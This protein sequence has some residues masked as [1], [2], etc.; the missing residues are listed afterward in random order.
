MKQNKLNR[1]FIIIFFI[2]T[3]ILPSI[4]GFIPEVEALTTITEIGE[5]VN[6]G[7]TG[8]IQE[9]EATVS[10]EYQLEVWGAQGG[11]DICGYD[12]YRGG[13]GGYSKGKITLKAGDKLYVAVGGAGVDCPRTLNI[14]KNSSSKVTAGNREYY[15]SYSDFEIDEGGGWNGGGQ[16]I[17]IGDQVYIDPDTERESIYSRYE[18]GGGGGATSIQKTLIGDGQLKNYELDTTDVCIV[19]GGGGGGN[20]S[21]SSWID[22]EQYSSNVIGGYGG[23]LNGEDSICN[24][25]GEGDFDLDEKSFKGGSQ[26]SGYK[27]GLGYFK[28]GGGWYGGTSADGWQTYYSGSGGSGYIGG[29]IEGNTTS[30][31]RSG[32]GYARITLLKASAHKLTINA[33]GGVYQ[34]NTNV[35]IE[36]GK[37]VTV[38]NPTRTGWTF[39]GWTLI[40]AGSSINGTTF[41]MGTEDATLTANWQLITHNIT[42]NVTWIDD[43]NKY[44]LRPNN[45]QVTL[46][47][48]P[49]TGVVKALPSSI[50][51]TPDSTKPDGKKAYTFSDV[52]TY[53]T[54]T[55]KAY[56]Y[57]VNQNNIGRNYTTTI[58]GFEI[59][60]KLNTFTI[61]GVVFLDAIEG[62]N[63]KY[64]LGEEL[65]KVQVTLYD[66]TGKIVAIAV[67]GKNGSYKFENLSPTKKYKIK[68]TYNGLLYENVNYNSVGTNTS[69]VRENGRKDFNKKFNNIG[70]HPNNYKTTDW[71]TNADITNEIFLEEVVVELFKEVTQ[72]I[73]KQSGNEKL[74]YSTLINK[75]GNTNIIKKKIQFIKDLRIDAYTELLD[76]NSV[77]LTNGK[78][79]Q[80]NINCGIKPRKTVDIAINTDI[81]NIEVQ[82]NNK[83]ERYEYNKRTRVYRR[84]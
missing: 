18:G 53:D 80:N 63:E 33:N 81:Y 42:G 28:C 39:T 45:V 31:A 38:N 43:N 58:K 16:M 72:E 34:G 30:N 78:Y 56:K 10:G 48:T 40:G 71:N 54:T 27:F 20:A 13:Y 17:Y 77:L 74:A 3:I 36:Q 60:N 23:G 44:N 2:I 41:T 76:S 51:V 75:Y 25:Q 35:D 64:D 68:F 59:I 32:D 57:W 61:Q 5:Y 46:S 49:N 24:V 84:N 7:Y 55:G 70:S 22:G 82:I 9:F 47:R 50:N 4:S 67:T 6:Y 1:K 37:T 52:Q 21:P 73:V 29:V 8:Y 79:I 62:G 11:Y 65:E 26:D 66:E 69:K 12:T 83:I 15:I 14:W 19:A